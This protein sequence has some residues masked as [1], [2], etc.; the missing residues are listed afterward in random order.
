[1]KRMMLLLICLLLP[2]LAHAEEET[3]YRL[4][5]SVSAETSALLALPMAESEVLLPLAKGETVTVTALG[6]R[7]CE[8]VS[9][10]TAGYIAT[11]DVAFDIPGGHKV[12][13]AVVDVSPTNQH[14]GRLTLREKDSTKSR[15]LCKLPRGTIVLLAEESGRM[16]RVIL[17][18]TEGYVLK[19]YVD[20]VSAEAD[21]RIA[22][23]APDV[24]A[25][26]RLD[27][28]YSN[29]ARIL[30][31]P[32][33]TPVQF[34]SNPNGWASVEAAGYRARMLASYLTFDAPS[35]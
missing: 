2:C 32:A 26:L 7:Y 27:S 15:A 9:G 14:S 10:E 24:D 13:L 4:T 17:P 11:L 1:M 22:Y 23:V 25:W 12:R 30:R 21:Y 6:T 19:N 33:G 8:A 34:F 5:A 35:E 16:V 29:S 3:P 31:L 18:D 20:A 28:R